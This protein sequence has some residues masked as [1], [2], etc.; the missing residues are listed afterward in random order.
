MP[1]SSITRCP[2]CRCPMPCASGCE[3]LA[4]VRQRAKRASAS[5]SLAV[6]A[7]ALPRCRADTP[8]AAIPGEDVV[9][10]DVAI[11]PAGLLAGVVRVDPAGKRVASV[12]RLSLDLAT[13]RV[14][15]VGP[16]IGD[17]PAP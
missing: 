2:A 3:R 10:G 9:I 1:R 7:E 4:A 15:D 13:V 17:D 8:R 14:V 5:S 12:A 6:V 11:G 16:A